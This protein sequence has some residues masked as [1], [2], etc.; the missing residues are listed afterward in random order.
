VKQAIQ[1]ERI[2]QLVKKAGGKFTVQNLMS[3]P[4]QQRESVEI[5]DDRLDTLIKLIIKECA[6]VASEG[7]K[8]AH[9]WHYGLLIEQHFGLD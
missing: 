8:G 9:P 1:N 5:W 6:D 3:N 2:R 4:P 7:P